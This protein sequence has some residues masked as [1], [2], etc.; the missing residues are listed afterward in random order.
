[1]SAS[2]RSKGPFLSRVAALEDWDLDDFQ[3]DQLQAYGANF[4]TV[5]DATRFLFLDAW[6]GSFDANV[7]QAFVKLVF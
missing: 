3:V 2:V 4:L 6:Y 1:M 5:D 7:A